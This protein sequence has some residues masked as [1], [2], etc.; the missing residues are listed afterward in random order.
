[1]QLQLVVVVSAKQGKLRFG[2]TETHE[3]YVRPMLNSVFI[4]RAEND[5]VVREEG[6]L[7]AFNL[8]ELYAELAH[9]NDEQRTK[10]GTLWCAA[11]EFDWV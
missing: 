3:M 9:N 6:V 10:D 4:C 8:I 7:K 11:C 5:E 1:M 2:G